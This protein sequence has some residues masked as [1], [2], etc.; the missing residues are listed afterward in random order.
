[1]DWV[2]LSLLTAVAFTAYTLVQKRTLDRHVGSVFEF[3]L[4]AALLQGS[5]SVLILIVSQP[6]WFSL[7]VLTMAAAGLLMAA[8]QLL[9]GYAI[10]REEDVSRIVPILDSYPLFVLIMALVLLGEA[11]TPMKGF[12]AL[13]VIGGAMLA[14][15]HQALPG[16]RVRLNRSLAAVAGAA[17]IIAV[18][19]ILVKVAAANVAPLQMFALMWVFALPGHVLATRAAGRFSAVR[20]VLATPRSMAW[21]A[22]AQVP[23]LIASLAWLW[24]IALGPVSL[25]S[26]MVGT[27]PVLLL[28]WAVAVG[29]NY[30]GVVHERQ[31]PMGLR[32]KWAAAVMV[33]LGV[34]AMAA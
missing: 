14:S 32:S 21:I 34:A 22:M 10:R 23:L 27:R 20:Q 5:L 25:V 4:I 18:L 33:T 7:G 31:A 8:T 12:A 29:V 19:S 9:Q 28:V 24:A 26:A 3:A 1:M 30:R 15:W 6:D 2:L 16:A 17:V 11:L 13:L